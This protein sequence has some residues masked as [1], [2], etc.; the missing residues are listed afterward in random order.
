MRTLTITTAGSRRASLWQAQSITWEELCEKFREPVRGTETYAE[1]LKLPKSQQD[2]LKDVGGYVG[3]RFKYMK[4]RAVDLVSRDLITLD[5]DQIPAQGTD[6]VLAA[7]EALSCAAAVYS[8]RKH[9]PRRPRLRVIVPIDR[10]VSPDE[11][12]PLARM[13]ASSIGLSYCDP[14]TFEG[15]RLMYWPSASADAEFVYRVFPG[16]PVSAGNLLALY[17]DWHDVSKWPRLPDEDASHTRS[18]ARAEDPLTKAGLV[19]AFCRVYDVPG[20]M[21]ELLPGLYTETNDPN[22]RT[23][24]GGSTY[25]GAVIYGDGR[26]L[27]S[28][29]ATDPCGGRLVN[30]WDL[31]RIQKFGDLDTEA[32]DGT[33]VTRLPSTKK[34]TDFAL[35]NRRVADLLNLERAEHAREVFGIDNQSQSASQ[36]ASDSRAGTENSRASIEDS[37]EWMDDLTK[38]KEGMIEKTIANCVTVLEHD[39]NL[40]GS[41]GYSELSD[42]ITAIGPLPW[43]RAAVRRRWT[44]ADD[45]NTHSYFE[46]VYGID[47]VRKVDEALTIVSTRHSYNEIAE[48]LQGLTWDGTPRLDTLLIDYLGAEDNVY[49]RAVMRKALVAA[50]ARVFDAGVKWDIMPILAGDQGIGKSTLLAALGKDW[51]SDSLTTFEGKTAAELI[52][53]VWIVEIG[54]LT[55]MSKQEVNSVKQFLSKRD[56]QYRA[57]YAKRVEKRPRHCVFFGTS[58]DLDFLKDQT[59]NRRFWPVDVTGEGTKSVWEDLKDEVDQIWAEAKVRYMLGEKLDLDKE[60]A[61]LAA[62]AQ[63]FHREV[64]AKEMAVLD[65]LDR[66][67]PTDWY[68]RSAMMRKVWLNDPANETKT[69]EDEG[70]MRRDKVCVAEIWVECFG[71]DIRQI[72]TI[73]SREIGS[74]MRNAPGWKKATGL[75]FGG[76]AYG[77]GR[78]FKRVI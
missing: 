77:R 73:K 69:L 66:P 37:L 8:T 19:G 44:D 35:G 72:D 26:F 10:E 75:S 34:M 60:E 71:G 53:G 13:L 41:V 32:K 20:A 54:E 29:H 33:P 59:G 25:G 51:F 63:E 43:N 30:A 57:A 68:E 36:D 15:S 22:R 17:D 40:T 24:A 38:T 18:A 4:R 58:N 78:G 23:F 1:Y 3:G 56:D 14:T 27:Y 39:P 2:A 5:L 61:E 45:A 62:E 16:G 65:F 48:Y 47:T 50:V 6:D 67:I 76:N 28:H 11:Y 21:D 70:M 12:E 64:S 46:A 49:T 7:V 55:A 31:V 9:S 42:A 74:I 52:Q